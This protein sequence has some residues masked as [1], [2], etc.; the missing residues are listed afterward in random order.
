MSDFERLIE[1]AFPLKQASLD[2]VHEKNVRH[3][4]ISTL[5]I[6][7]AR[8]PLAASRAALIAALLSDPGSPEDR[9]RVCELVGGRVSKRTEKK[10]MPNGQVVEREKEITEGGVLH[11]GREVENEAAF[12]WIREEIRRRF[13]NTSPKVLDPF[14]GGGAIPLEAMR[15]GCD[16]TAI[17]INPVAWFI[18]RCTLEYPQKLAARSCPLPEFILADEDFMEE[19]YKANPHLSGRTKPTKKQLREKQ[20]GLFVKHDEMNQRSPNAELAWQVRAWGLWVLSQ[21]RKDLAQY[22]PTYADFESAERRNPRPY[23]KKAPALVP[24]DEKGRPN[25]AALNGEFTAEYLADQRNPRWIAKPTVAY[26]WARTVQCKNCRTSVPLLKTLWLCKKGAK[27][28]KL[29]IEV[30]QDNSSFS[31]SICPNVPSVG[32]NVAERREHDK[33]IGAGTMSRAGAKCPCCKTIS[34][35]EDIRLEG[36]AGR[37]GSTMVCVVVESSS[38]KEYRKPTEVDLAASSASVPE[39]LEKQLPFGIP[40]EPL[41]GKEALGFRIPLYGYTTWDKLYTSRQLTALAAL[42]V[43]TREVYQLVRRDSEDPVWAEAIVSYLAAAL[44]RTADYMTSFCVWENGAEEV[45]HLFMRWALPVTWDFAEGNPL[46]PIERFYLG[47]LNSAFRVLRN[48]HR[49][50]WSHTLPP[51]ILKQSAIANHDSK[52]DLIVTDPP[53]YDAIPYSDLMDFFYVWLRRTLFGISPE[54]DLAFKEELSPKWDKT[55]RDGELIDDASRHENDAAKSK[56]EY[57]EG[58][59]RAFSSAF[60]ALADNG[61]FIV[62]FAHKQP[63]AWETLVSAMFRAGFVVDGSWPIQ[64]EMPGGIRNLGRAS[65]SSSVWLICKK[66]ESNARPGWDNRVI[67]QM[68]ENIKSRLREYWDAGI[69]GPDFVWAATGPALE[70]YSKHPIVKKADDPNSLMTVSEFLN[71]VRRI[72]V[73]FVVGRVLSGV[74]T[75]ENGDTLSDRMD[76]VTAYYLLHRHDFGLE[77][78]PAGSCI[79]Y[80]VSCGLSDKELADSWDI[81]AFT[82]DLAIEEVEESDEDADE[83]PETGLSGKGVRLKLW[84][85]RKGSELGY[86]APEGK[87]VPLIDRI[88]RLMRLWREGDI[89]RVDEYLDEYGLRKN[90]LFKR[91]V[92]SVIELSEHGGEERTLLERLSNHIQGKGAVREDVEAYFSAEM[93]KRKERQ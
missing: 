49:T 18:L 31:L 63:D 20:P 74:G 32:S 79:L 83:L 35:M 45:K 59:F 43:R 4:H 19:F 72:V 38:G 10:S 39:W 70:A 41:P 37:L 75:A 61:R 21:V 91:L 23:E 78:A 51:R 34:G 24:V 60:N 81:I 40:T 82:N 56:S 50:Q 69:R 71:R 73:D 16:T 12:Q 92:Q 76:E 28:V 29:D 42:C 52:Y 68:V 88:H 89:H 93:K 58:M 2:S 6:W 47:G 64:T 27:R 14:A 44:S 85:Q 22:Y 30:S 86:R 26:L 13:G 17:D 33:R 57:E 1:H 9:K 8:R 90:E 53:Y 77:E 67:E 5:H 48:L 11:W 54:Y 66:R 62:V 7:P 15:L 3:G 80:A 25:V 46:A 84:H 36:Q 87:S 65:L 55:K